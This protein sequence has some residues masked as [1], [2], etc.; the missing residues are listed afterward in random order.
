[1]PDTPLATNRIGDQEVEAPQPSL[2]APSPIAPSNLDPLWQQMLERLPIGIAV[3][4]RRSQQTLWI[5]PA[6][7][8]LLEGAIGV[9]AVIGLSPA[10]YLPGLD[11]ERWQAVLKSVLKSEPG[12][13]AAQRLQFVHYTTRNITYWDWTLQPIEDGSPPHHLMLLVESVSER[14]MNERLLGS[15]VRKADRALRRAEALA[16]LTQQ[17]NA[18]MTTQEALRNVTQEAAAFFET[19]YAAVLLL[20]PEGRQFEIGYGI[21]LKETEPSLSYLDRARTLADHAL[22]ERKT[23]VLTGDRIKSYQTP[24]LANGKPPAA[25]ISSPIWHD[26]RIYGAL[27]VY[28]DEPRDFSEDARALMMAF[29]NQTAIALAKADLYEQVAAQRR[30]LQTIFD[31]APVGILYFDTGQRILAVNA[32][33]ARIFGQPLETLAGQTHPDLLRDLPPGLFDQV[34]R[35]QPFHASHTIFHSDRPEHEGIVCDLSL[36]PVRDE[37]GRVVG[38]LMLTFN[39]TELVKAR[40]EADAARAAAETALDHVRAAQSQMVQMEKMRAIGELASGVAHDFNNALMTILGYA[41]IAEETLDDPETLRSHLAIIRK[42]AE[43]AASTVQRLQR[44]ARQRVVANGAPTDVNLIVQD[45]IEMTRPRWKDTAQKEG[46]TYHVRVDLNPVPTILAEP[47]GLREVLVNMIHNALNAMPE[48]G[49]LTLST[50]THGPQQVEIEVADTGIG[51][52]PEVVARVFDPFFTT[53]GVEGTG[54]GLAVSWTIVQR[55]G[56]TIAVESKPGEGTRFFVRLPINAPEAATQSEQ[57][58]EIEPLAAQARLLV[59]DDEPFVASVLM[60]I[61]SRHGYRVTVAHSAQEALTLLREKPTEYNMVLT[62]HGMPG[63]TGLQLVEEIKRVWPE[64]PVVLLTGWGE[65]LLQMHSAETLPDVV[66]AKP[67]NQSDLLDA[68]LRVFHAAAEKS[69]APPATPW[70][71]APAAAERD[72][73]RQNGAEDKPDEK[74]EG[75]Q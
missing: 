20:R 75:R 2:T 36:L 70:E 11:A 48:G 68:L 26:D 32:A 21:G 38:V 15:A 19:P 63:M 58:A 39:V 45:V 52:P 27:E 24:N 5:N 69:P 62:D 13:A 53:R 25:I 12:A 14:V 57:A 16:R 28:S 64:M 56:G 29:A 66:L 6:L 1:M 17:V 35:G 41:E 65:N 4:D 74:S 40:Q 54:L 61:L 7:Q 49:T 10:K 50:R 71:G 67:I 3:L 55:H 23:L 33:A 51:M 73:N 46:R 18:S 37:A 34:R 8:T 30:Q 43:D 44:F 72:G 47:S 31:N 60:S 59:V 42:A 22:E 9:C